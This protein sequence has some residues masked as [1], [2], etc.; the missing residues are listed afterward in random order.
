MPDS[1]E[2]RTPAIVIGRGFTG[3]GA[4]RSLV[5]GGISA[6]IACPEGDL[7]TRSRWYRAPPGPEIWDGDV[8]PRAAAALQASSLA[9]AV[10]I[11][12]SDDAA[13]WLADHAHTALAE[14]FPV[15]SSSRETLEIFQDK[16]RFGEFLANTGVPHPRTLS[17]RERADVDRIPF[18][19]GDRYFLKPTDSQAFSQALGAKGVWAHSR[20]EFRTAWE[21]LAAQGFQVVAQEY[22]PGTSADHFFVDG[23]RDR[24]GALPGLFARRRE[25]IFPADFGNS[26]YCRS[27]ALP[28]V[29]PA[30]ADLGRLLAATNYRGIFSA[31]FK[32]DART[33]AFRLLEVN[34]RAWWY[35]EFAARCGVNVCRMAH[36]DA[37][38]G[39]VTTPARPYRVGAGCVSQIADLK[40]V[41]TLPPERR[42][43]WPTILRQW[44]GAHR[45]VFR[46]DDPWPG[47]TELLRHAQWFVVKRWRALHKG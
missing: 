4:L 30:V 1:A 23:F 31:E 32:R 45:H 25:R 21:R 27:I 3:L 35:V 7:A 24:H 19:D 40:A 5:L 13:M 37:L 47:M 46:W 11:P 2:R 42:G 41:L 36:E 10:L 28:E 15:S 12:G 22:V 26:S 17:L 16:A 9:R 44:A 18:G 20:E 6:F 29:A 39:P 14:R 33:G 34:T 43:G 8:G 38:G